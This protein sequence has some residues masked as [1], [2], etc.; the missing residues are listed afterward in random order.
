MAKTTRLSGKNQITVPSQFVRE[1]GLS[2]GDELLVQI[3][4]GRVVLTPKPASLTDYIRGRGRGMYG[5]DAK[6]ID[7]YIRTERDSW[8]ANEA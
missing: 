5:R 3:I 7:E 6:E 4:D 1:L 8:R 2:P